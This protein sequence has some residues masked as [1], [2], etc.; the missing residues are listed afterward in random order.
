MFLAV[1]IGNTSTVFGI[2][3]GEKLVMSFRTDTGNYT[4]EIINSIKYPV[5]AAAVSS[6][7]PGVNENICNAISRNLGCQVKIIDSSFKLGIS[8]CTEYPERVGTDIICGAVAA[9]YKYRKAVVVFDLGTATTVCAVD[10][11]GNYLGHSI[12][13]G[14]K[15]S[16]A[17][18]HTAAAKLPLIEDE[19]SCTQIIGKN[20]VSSMKSGVILGAACFIDGMSRRYRKETDDNA[21]VVVTGGLSTVILPYCEDKYIFDENLLMD[22][23]RLIYELNKQLYN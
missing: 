11:Q 2:Y 18:L 16:F 1:D 20:T 13:P 22:G 23:I 9:F 12:F 15:T 3:D 4:D 21:T 10:N 7:V 8:I 6:V 14:V 5:E 17:A 19:Y